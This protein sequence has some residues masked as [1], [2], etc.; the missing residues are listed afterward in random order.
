MKQRRVVAL[1]SAALC[2]L[3]A[4]SAAPLAAAA[5]D[6]P[7]G[8]KVP[9]DQTLA[10]EL[11]AAGVQIYVCSARKDDA[12]KFEWTLKAPEAELFDAAGKKI[13]KHYGGP[14]WEADDGSKV[15]GEVKARDDGP[16]PTAIPWLLLSAKATS[17]SGILSKTA[18]VQRLRTVGGKAPAT[19]CNQ[20]TH[21]GMEVRVPYKASYYFYAAKS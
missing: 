15:V 4:L 19:G 2:V 8:L 6:V 16:D 3:L 7:D 12:T 9:A 13:G 21:A 5:P 18:S 14:T 17:G 20:A 1:P 11:Q 10:L